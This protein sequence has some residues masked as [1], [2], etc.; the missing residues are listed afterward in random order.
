M[1]Q[2]S[3]YYVGTHV[4]GSTTDQIF[5]I[6]QILRKEM[7][8]HQLFVDF[9]KTYDLVTKTFLIE[10]GA[11]MDLVSSTSCTLRQKYENYLVKENEMGWACSTNGGEEGKRPLGRPRHRWVVNI[12]MSL[13]EVWPGLFRLIIRQ[14]ETS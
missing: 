14:V 4:D 11:L 10:L 9:K 5:C 12:K 7:G 3:I 8:V 13:G 1:D 2:S 6:R